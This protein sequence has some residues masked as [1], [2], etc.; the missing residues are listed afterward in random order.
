MRR[1]DSLKE[2]EGTGVA[3]LPELR[4][5]ILGCKEPRWE[6]TLARS[7]QAGSAFWLP[8]LSLCHSL[9]GALQSV[10]KWTGRYS[11]WGWPQGSKGSPGDLRMRR[12]GPQASPG[13]GDV[14]GCFYK[15]SWLWYAGQPVSLHAL[16]FEIKLS[17]GWRVLVHTTGRLCPPGITALTLQRWHGPELTDYFFVVVA[18]FCLFCDRVSWIPGS[19]SVYCQG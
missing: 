14:P 19:N 4:G 10:A 17:L 8:W 6:R 5:L 13:H 7:Q 2:Q 9:P 1:E 3:S 12:L 16:L 18:G 15:A 11:P